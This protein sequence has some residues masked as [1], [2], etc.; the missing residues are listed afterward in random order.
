[1]PLPVDVLVMCSSYLHD[2]GMSLLISYINELRVTVQE[3]SDDT[4]EVGNKV[5]LYQ[6][7]L[8]DGHVCLPEKYTEK[9]TTSL[10]KDVADFI[11]LIHPWISA[12]YITA[13]TGFRKST[14]RGST[15]KI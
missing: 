14:I 11:R 4:L 12:K 8:R 10:S 9:Y 5:K 7:F 13:G 3:I 6:N 1:M 2:V 15:R